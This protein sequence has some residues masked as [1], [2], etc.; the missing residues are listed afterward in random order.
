MIGLERRRAFA[1][2]LYL[3]TAAI[4]AVIAA[5]SSWLWL[6]V[7]AVAS[8]GCRGDVCTPEGS[9][10]TAAFPVIA[11]ISGAAIALISAAA[12][13][14]F[15]LPAAWV[16]VGIPLAI[17]AYFLAPLLANWVHSAGMW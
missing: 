17:A 11:L 9:H 10:W 7:A 4:L 6:L 2:G 13:A 15:R 5:T 12:V 8:D 3:A 14:V 16:W 1:I